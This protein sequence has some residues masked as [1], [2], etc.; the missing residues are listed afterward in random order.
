M[1]GLIIP[2]VH[3]YLLRLKIE[4][5]VAT[6]VFIVIIVVTCSTFSELVTKWESHKLCNFP[7]KMIVDS[8]PGCQ[9]VISFSVLHLP[10]LNSAHFGCGFL[11]IQGENKLE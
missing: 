2:T 11:G 7:K 5:I 3:S 8:H 1:G 4:S 6:T 9:T 10:A